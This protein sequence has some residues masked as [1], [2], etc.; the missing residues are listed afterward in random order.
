MVSSLCLR[1]MGVVLMLALL[2]SCRIES[3]APSTAPLV[4][5]LEGA[6]SGDVWVYTSMYRHVLDALDPLLQEKLPHV[7]VHWYQAGSEKVASRL[8]AER[9]A[10]A[11]R[12]DVLAT[13]DPFL[14][15]RLTREGA[16]LRYASPNVLRVPR[17]LMELDAHYAAMRL[18]TMVL[19]RRQGLENPP[20]A[21][22]DLIS[23]RWKGRTA[24]GDPLTSGTAFTWAVFLQAKYG[25]TFF[26]R[27]RAKGTIVAG[28]NAAVLQKVE[29]GEADVGVLLLENALAAR[30]R[31]SP[32]A[33][34]WP[35]DGA[36]VIPGPVAIFQTTPNPTAA[37][38]FVDVLLSPEG[39]RIIAGKG[40]MH[41]VDPRLEGPRG[42][43]G[44]EAL[45]ARTQPWTPE[46]L[47]RGLVRGGELK[48]LFSRAF[49]Q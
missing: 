27:L 32:I 18:S 35:T 12:A 17:S 39:Q 19:V 4:S 16:F 7:Q 6:P 20:S 22:G 2:A 15:E 28:G 30:E 9:T 24:I 36:V 43:P 10:G 11:V 14:Y 26:E 34:T 38:A 3:A 47:E 29:S 40:D 49:S 42:E 45:M 13:S 5:R 21:F 48:E 41:A 25:D 37:K 1:S 44:L 23:E 33:F 46:L 31:G 8:E